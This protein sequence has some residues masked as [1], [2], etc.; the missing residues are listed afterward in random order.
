VKRDRKVRS[1]DILVVAKLV[2][3]SYLDVKRITKKLMERVY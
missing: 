1:S 2:K 3:C